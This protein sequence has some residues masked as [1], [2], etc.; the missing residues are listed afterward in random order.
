MPFLKRDITKI[1]N[2]YGHSL[3]I[4]SITWISIKFPHVEKMKTKDSDYSNILKIYD[5]QQLYLFGLT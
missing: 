3:N 1:L 5:L 2:S 4:C